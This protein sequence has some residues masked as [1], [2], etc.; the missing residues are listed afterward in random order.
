MKYFICLFF[1]FS[2]ILSFEPLHLTFTRILYKITKKKKNEK[3]RNKIEKTIEL[4]GFTCVT[5]YAIRDRMGFT[6]TE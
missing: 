1:F 6:Q 5:V 3:N 2:N 4:N